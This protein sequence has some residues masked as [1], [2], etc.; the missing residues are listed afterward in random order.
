MVLGE[1]LNSLI[2]A[3][4]LVLALVLGRYPGERTIARLA[5]SAARRTERPRAPRAIPTRRRVIFA[6]LRASELLARS[7]AT[8]PP[9]ALT[10]S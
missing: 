3:F 5:E 2:P 6:E 4:A 7:L 9:P 8:R 1:L 10:A